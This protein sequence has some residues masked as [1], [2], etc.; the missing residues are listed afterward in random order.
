MF[1]WTNSLLYTDARGNV[2]HMNNSLRRLLIS[3]ALLAFFTGAAAG[4]PVYIITGNGTAFTVTNDNGATTLATD[5]SIQTV[6]D[7]IKVNASSAPCSIQFGNG[8]TALNIETAN[9]TFDGGAGGNDWGLITLS[10]KITS[11]NTTATAGTIS[12]T[13]G[14]SI[15]SEADVANT[16]TGT[17]GRAIYSNTTETVTISGGTVSANTGIAIYNA[18]TG[19][20]IISG[21]QTVVT[22][23][24]A[25]GTA[26]T[27]LG[28]IY[29][30]NIGNDTD[31]RLEINGGTIGNTANCVIFNVSTGAVNINGGEIS[32]TTGNWMIY[33]YSTGALNI[34]GGIVSAAGGRAIQNESAGIVTISGGE[35][36]ATTGYAVY[37]NASG[38]IHV[39][40][41]GKVYAT[42]NNGYALHNQAAGTVTI[43]G[44][45]ISATTGYAVYNNANGQIDIANATVSATGNNGYAIHNQ[46][47]GTVN[48]TD[49]TISVTSGTGSRAISNNGAGTVTIA[50]GEISATVG[51]AVYNA[52]AGRITISGAQTVIT[53]TNTTTTS[54]TIYNNAAGII[55]IIDGIVENTGG[56]NVNAIYC[57]NAGG[58]VI[59]G[60]DPEITGRI[61]AYMGKIS[62]VTGQND[63]TD[64]N[65]GNDRAYTLDLLN[66]SENTTVVANGGQQ[67]VS[68]FTLIMAEYH[69]LAAKNGDIVMTFGPYDAVL[70]NGVWVVTNNSD[71]GTW[72]HIQ[73]VI[74]H[75]KT[76]TGGSGATIQFGN[77]TDQLNIGR[78]YI[79][80]D[81]TGWGNITLTGRLTS[82]YSI[83]A[84]YGTIYLINGASITSTANISNTVASAD[85]R[86]IYNASTGTVTINGGAVSAAN[87]RAIHN[88][89]AGTVNITGGT[90]SATTG[91]AIY[92]AA[93]AG[94]ITISGG[95]QTVVTSANAATSFGTIHLAAGTAADTLLKITGGIVRN[96]ANNSSARAIYN[97][98]SGTVN[99][100]GGTVSITTTNSYTAFA[101]QNNSNGTINISGGTVHNDA[102][103]TGARAIN[104]AAAGKVTISG[105]TV[106]AAYGVAV[107]NAAANGTI[108]I[109]NG[110]V[111]SAG[112]NGYAV[113]CDN[114]NS[115][116]ALGGNP[117]IEGRIRVYVGGKL[118]VIPVSEDPINYFNPAS[119]KIYTVDLAAYTEGGVVAAGGGGVLEYFAIRQPY[120]LIKNNNN[121]VLL[122]LGPFSV[123]KIG[124]SY[125]LTAS[126]GDYVTLQEAIN[127]I[128]GEAA[129]NPCSIRFGSDDDETLNIDNKNI[130]FNGNE[131]GTTITLSGK[132]TSANTSAS[133]GTISLTN[134]VS[135]VSTADIENTYN[136]ANAYAIYNNSIGTVTISGGTVSAT[137]GRAIQNQTTGTVTVTGSGKVSTNSSYISSNYA[138]A[139]NSSGEIKI[140]GGTVAANYLAIYNISTGTVTV[141][142]GRV[143]TD[144]LYSI[145]NGAAGTITVTG[146]EVSVAGSGVNNRAIYNNST[147]PVN[148]SGGTVSATSG[149]AIYNVS[150]GKITISG[151]ATVTSENITSSSGT[152]FLAN[153]GT[154]TATR[155][156]IIGGRVENTA[157]GS[158]YY[159]A[160]VYNASTGAIDISGGTVYAANRY[161]VHNRSSGTVNV[162]GNGTISADNDYG[163]YN[164]A[165]ATVNI[166]GGTVSALRITVCNNS[167]GTINITGGTITSTSN[168]TIYNAVNGIIN[169]SGGDI[170][171]YN[172]INSYD[173]TG[174]IN[175]I[176]GKITSTGG[177]II[178]RSS[179]S[180]TGKTV[181]S[182]TAELTAGSPSSALY[183]ASGEVEITGGKIENTGGGAAIE[184]QSNCKKFVMSNLAQ[185]IS[186]GTGV[187]VRTQDAEIK[188]NG[189][190]ISTAAENGYAVY[191][192]SYNGA[193][194]SISLG[195]T[196][197]ITGR[198]TGNIGLLSVITGGPDKFEPE[199]GKIYDIDFNYYSDNGI[200]VVGGGAL[201][202]HFSLK[203]PVYAIFAKEGDIVMSALTGPYVITQENGYEF[204]I[205]WDETGSIM[206]IQ[207]ALDTIKARAAG[208][209]C[210]IQFGD[211]EIPLNTESANITF[212]G[213]T[214][215]ND[216]GKV[217]I[218]GRLLSEYASDAMQG[219]I[220]LT[221]GASIEVNADIMSGLGR[222]EVRCIYNA[223]TGSVDITGGLVSHMSGVAVYNESAGTVN[224]RGG[225][226]LT[227]GTRALYSEGPV[228]ISGGEVVAGGGAAV[229]VDGPNAVV[230]ISGSAKVSSTSDFNDTSGVI[231]MTG[232]S[233]LTITGGTVE[234]TSDR[235][236]AISSASIG[237]I[238][239]SGGTVNRFA[240][241]YYYTYAVRNS[242]TGNVYISGGTVTGPINST[243]AG[244]VTVLDGANLTRDTN[245]TS[246]YYP[247]I[248]IDTARAGAAV[249]DTCLEIKGGMLGYVGN[250]PS[251]VNS[252]Y[253]VSNHSDKGIYISGGTINGMLYQVKGQLEITGGTIAGGI[254]NDSSGVLML[255]GA[256]IID[257][258]ISTS[259]RG[260][261]GVC[262]QTAVYPFNPA[263]GVQYRLQ[264]AADLNSSRII[265]YDGFTVVKNGWNQRDKF[266]IEYTS[267]DLNVEQREKNYNGDIVI[268][269]GPYSV[270]QNGYDFTLTKSAAGDILRVQAAIDTIKAR[271]AGNE[272]SI[273]FGNG[274]ETLDVG[275][276]Y[277]TFDGGAA[278]N[279]WGKITL[280]G[281]L[282]SSRYLNYSWGYNNNPDYPYGRGAIIWLRNGVTMD[283]KAD[284]ANTSDA[285][286]YNSKTIY[287]SSGSVTISAGT[288]SAVYGVAVYGDSV[289]QITV[290]GTAV[291]TSQYYAVQLAN[292]N[293]KLD[294]SGGRVEKTGD[295]WPGYAIYNG[296]AAVN[297][298]G[299]IVDGKT[300][301]AIYNSANNCYNCNGAQGTVTISGAA[302]VTSSVSST[303]ATISGPGKL[304]ISGATVENT[305]SADSVRAIYLSDKGTVEVTGGTISAANGV[306]GFAIYSANNDASSTPA[307]ITL[308]GNPNI[309]GIMRV[310]AG[311]FTVN[312][313]T[314][315]PVGDGY[316]LD[317]PQYTDGM[318]VVNGGGSFPT[319]FTIN[320]PNPNYSVV[321]VGNDLRLTTGPYW[322]TQSVGN[323]FTLERTYDVVNGSSGPFANP[324]AAI[325]TIRVRAN[326]QD[327]SIQFGD[328]TTPLD[329][330]DGSV[331]FNGGT[332]GTDWGRITLLGKLTSDRIAY[333]STYYVS[334]YGQVTST[335][336]LGVVY[337]RRGVTVDVK[338]EISNTTST[339]GAYTI[340]TV[341]TAG[342]TNTIN[343]SAG[344]IFSERGLAVYAGSA[345]VN[346]IGGEITSNSTSSAL[347]GS[348]QITIDGSG[349]IINGSISGSYSSSYTSTLTIKNGTIN[350]S[351]SFPSN[352]TSTIIGGIINGRISNSGIL[353]ITG[354][355]VSAATGTAIYNDQTVTITG[356]TIIGETAISGSS[357]IYS[358]SNRKITVT[359]GTI[360]AT[361]VDGIAFGGADTLVLGGTPDITGSIT[362][363]NRVFRVIPSGEPN[364]FTPGSSDLYTLVVA[365]HQDGYV[366]VENGV[367][368][369]TNFTFQDLESTYFSVI[370][371][372]NNLV[373]KAA[374]QFSQGDGSENNPYIIMTDDDL[375]L[376]AS[377]IH[378]P[379]INSSYRDKHY[380]LGA[381]IN[382]ST[383]YGS[384]YS[385]G[386]GNGWIPIGKTNTPFQGT[387][388]GADFT[389]SG[390]YI[391]RQNIQYVGLF[392]YLSGTVT[393]KNLNV[394]ADY[395]SGSG[396]FNNGSSYYSAGHLGGLAGNNRGS[397]TIENCQFTG[398]ITGLGS[399]AGSNSL[400][401]GLVGSDSGSI[402]IKNCRFIGDV[403]GVTTTVNS[404]VGG[405]VGQSGSN[406][407][408]ENCDFTGNVSGA[409]TTGGSYVGGL[410]GYGVGGS[411][412]I[413]NCTIDGDVRSET[414][415]GSNDAGGLAGIINGSN[416]T[417]ENCQFTGNVRGV[418]SEA[419]SGSGHVGGLLG[420]VYG[421]AIENCHFIGGDVS[422]TV[423]TGGG[424]TGVGG[425]LGY[426]SNAAVISRSSAIANVNGSTYTGGI[427]GHIGS[428]TSELTEC[429]FDGTVTGTGYVGGLLGFFS[430]SDIIITDCVIA[431]N[432]NIIGNGYVGGVAGYFSGSGTITRTSFSANI[433][434]DSNY[435]GGLVGYSGSSGSGSTI[436]DSHTTG[437]ISAKS[438]VGGLV[439]W[440]YRVSITDSYSE[441]NIIGDSLVGGLVGSTSYITLTNSHSSGDITGTGW[442]I[443][444]LA[445]RNTGGSSNQA[446]DCYSTGNVRGASYVGGLF[447]SGYYTKII[448]SYSIGDV[449][450]TGDYIGGLA[451]LA[452]YYMEMTGSY[453]TGDVAGGGNYVGGL[454]GS[455]PS[456]SC[457]LRFTECYS[458]GNISG[459]DYV[460]GLF[461][462]NNMGGVKSS[463]ATGDVS[464]QDRVGGLMGCLV[465]C[466]SV[467]G[468]IT[469]SYSTGSVN[470]RHGVGGLVG[471]NT[472]GTITNSYTIS[473]VSG[474]DT[475]GGFVGY[476]TGNQTNISKNF[477]GARITMAPGK[478]AGGF[479]GN[480][481]TY[482]P[483]DDCYW[484]KDSVGL[485]A[486]SFTSAAGKSTDELKLAV[487]YASWDLNNTWGISDGVNMPYLRDAPVISLTY[488]AGPNGT[489]SAGV[490]QSARQIVQNIN[491]SANGVIGEPVT[492]VPDD[493]N[494]V[495][496]G[497]SDG[498]TSVTR[499]D[500]VSANMSVN[501]L[502]AS[503]DYFDSGTGD[504]NDPYMIMNAKQLA[505]MAWLVNDYNAV[506]GDKSYRLGASFSLSQD[507]GPTWDTAN[508]IGWIPIGRDDNTPFRGT[509]DGGGNTI[510]GLHINR[511]TE[512]YIGLF[513]YLGRDDDDTVTIKNVT[514][515]GTSITGQ[516]YTGGLAGSGGDF[517]GEINISKCNV[518]VIGDVEGELCVGGLLGYIGKCNIIIDSSSFVGKNV[519][520]GGFDGNNNGKGVG[521]LLGAADNGN[522]T[523][524]NSRVEADTIYSSEGGNIGGL[525]GNLSKWDQNQYVT[526]NISKSNFIGTVVSEGAIGSNNVG[527]ILGLAFN[528]VHVI[529]DSCEFEGTLF[530]SYYN[531]GGLLGGAGGDI[532]ISDSRVIADTI[533]GSKV[534]VGGLIGCT[535]TGAIDVENCYVTGNVIGGEGSVGGL[536]GVSQGVIGVE[537]C[538]VTGDVTGNGEAVGGL[539]GYSSG[540]MNI[541]NCSAAGNVT[542]GNNNV[543]G[544]A[545]SVNS[546]SSSIDSC[547]FEGTVT[548][549]SFNIGGI[550]G[551][552]QYGSVTNCYSTGMVTGT[553]AGNDNIGGIVGQ[554]AAASSGVKNCYATGAVSGGSNV[555][556][557]VGRNFGPVV[558]CAALNERVSA[559]VDDAA[560]RV[561]GY[562]GTI[563]PSG[564][565]A[566]SGMTITENGNLKTQ[567][568]NIEDGADISAAS[569]YANPAMGI[570]TGSGWATAVSRLPGFVSA[571]VT[572]EHL[573]PIFSKA[574]ITLSQN[575]YDYDGTAKKPGITKVE[576][577]GVELQE[578]AHYEVVGYANNTAVGTARVTIRGVGDLY[579]S[580]ARKNFTIIG[581][582]PPTTP[583]DAK[584]P[585]ITTQP[586]D[587]TVV[588]GASGATH[589]LT[590][591]AQ[592]P[593]GG[594]LSYQWYGNTSARNTGG[595]LIS[596]AAGASYAARIDAA[597]TFYYYVTVT[598]T[599]GNNGDGGKKT[600]SVTSDAA[601]VTVEKPKE[602]EGDEEDVTPVLSAAIPRITEQPV[603]A[604]VS[605]SGDGHT[606]TVSASVA[607]GGT[608]SYQWYNN[609]S[610]SNAGGAKIPDAT[611]KT[612]VHRQTRRGMFY[613]YAE[614]TNT[615]VA[616]SERRSASAMSEPVRVMDDDAREIAGVKFINPTS[617]RDLADRQ[618]DSAPS[619]LPVYNVTVMALDQFGSE[620]IDEPVNAQISV[621]LDDV[622]MSKAVRTN[623]RTGS[624]SFGA[625]QAGVTQGTVL[626]Y[627]AALISKG[628]R[629]ADTARLVITEPLPDLTPENGVPE[630]KPDEPRVLAGVK[631][632]SPASNRDLKAGEQPDNAASDLPVYT[633]RVMA[634]DQYG[635]GYTGAPVNMSVSVMLGGVYVSKP[636][637]TDAKT[638]TASFDVSQPGVSSGSVLTFVAAA[639]APDGAR[640]TDTARLSITEPALESTPDRAVP[641]I[642]RDEEAVAM[643]PVSLL[644]GEFMAGP[645]PVYKKSGVINFY[646]QG[647]R[648]ADSELRIYDVTGNVVSKVKISDGS[649]DSPVRRN[650]GTWDLRNDRGRPVPNGT[651]LL[652]GVLKTPDGKKENVSV[653]LGVR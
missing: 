233:A 288:V 181:V 195:G 529:I 33:N 244:K 81:G 357:Y 123:T 545:G 622:Y 50:S 318:A 390:L 535:S 573:I 25:N 196:P 242:S 202:P 299:G 544:L 389:I 190:T 132:I 130:T 150:T 201:L 118:R 337:L 32:I 259:V 46:A 253:A 597:G 83:D 637:R 373:M 112:A 306:D 168:N 366:V 34:S 140:T 24:N 230:T 340:S 601:T 125:T 80:L 556:G 457:G 330:V 21:D 485:P 329:I 114:A 345:T 15:I 59:L 423:A 176:A 421:A 362:C 537:N 426:S 222:S 419:T 395:V 160:T 264:V 520:G 156:E 124:N 632:I 191:V 188:I 565:V 66:Y 478:R 502:F 302:R 63:G 316:T 501:A 607:D 554:S 95:T 16:A 605:L 215:G 101:I 94:R 381:P 383:K 521:G 152:I 474:V 497:W 399:A 2:A 495:F 274:S 555:G 625:S 599:I 149:V 296:V 438:N 10:G 17:N 192:D 165:N 408:I 570:F 587:T 170:S 169:I 310:R 298:S 476:F 213:G 626:T 651:Y 39:N 436:T 377:V 231:Q 162:S 394:A 396:N 111:R 229:R 255:G 367:E 477:S 40:N 216:W 67:N 631:F 97:T 464:G 271:A 65:P 175:I 527:G 379:I 55:E 561:L 285:G 74:D 619:N 226:V 301:C 437:N 618:P 3:A 378:N 441:G 203:N 208:H 116:V 177:R 414:T 548:G 604:R 294:V 621:T 319:S 447:G 460:G 380:K 531:V 320:S 536:T 282:T 49:G 344:R 456:G 422:G 610:Y 571:E 591:T 566:F 268:T 462:Y 410:I 499:T 494:S 589:S 121:D 560:G 470:G 321:A 469:E 139:N 5:P 96:T 56:A 131:W 108:E 23:A 104:N 385:D 498:L 252:Y 350:G 276:E 354:G 105:G 235:G 427:A 432:V 428:S 234:N 466:S 458:A 358:Y 206:R 440:A 52:A 488:N 45:E 505:N 328:G 179:G 84:S 126:G 409:A 41:N 163:I 82:I 87:G 391:D 641:E 284:I 106:S 451:G 411:V 103:Q 53:S 506:Y 503:D 642:A 243:A 19:K 11:A 363:G 79:T 593:D 525:V 433:T 260:Q 248:R 649:A 262:P 400:V 401:G 209:D 311:K 355:T 247:A 75:I 327:C 592:S 189:G 634:L 612:Y 22:S 313:A 374:A 360:T 443:G 492:A 483:T 572:P 119:G 237:D 449:S 339:Y 509:F 236:T 157:V 90:V 307:E 653:I 76:Q 134:G 336:R 403:S 167:A 277:I 220:Y 122:T 71:N 624:A 569:I 397:A 211:G 496:N 353:T 198:I 579:D 359:G 69:K 146:G 61:R 351:V 611:E 386:G 583:V 64:F 614:V 44:G 266:I 26:S 166:S 541:E 364:A 582:E 171:G 603:G 36:S 147:G 467:N 115:N 407:T 172:V 47:A 596:G 645:N 563:M 129:G 4:Q 568:S 588:T 567:L 269:T 584:E 31:T 629:Y 110:T 183:I 343:I 279:A 309:I 217:T 528:F 93:A 580:T 388:D 586:R 159:S 194:T 136:Y 37:N 92:N 479:I 517:Y 513:G 551:V 387:F 205:L 239:I 158:S 417:I 481:L 207:E 38:Q 523:V 606:M 540:A 100:D 142:G 543:G 250:D 174:T 524:S 254:T 617:N 575:T 510:I 602:D 609:T 549:H 538:H 627:T 240:S 442:Y 218:L 60:G 267:N 384:Q 370:P 143:S 424:Y 224:V 413:K 141:S 278:R 9:V 633:V 650:V 532:R 245:T 598:N 287:S 145:Y 265:T 514:V 504:P 468:G 322:I 515:T 552:L 109:I 522:I 511:P 42:G 197:D 542:G 615:V 484:N 315:T 273:T 62:A 415:T 539:I 178:E 508:G 608:L 186:Q 594:K 54:G 13:N 286:G 635:K 652:R 578:T 431:E 117:N 461:G 500:A 491:P 1:G 564:N 154:A 475:V 463:Y 323:V 335:I 6:I 487:T 246:G 292:A 534:Q 371:A 452:E 293:A 493:I 58:S 553:G 444:G 30:A 193:N 382:L 261:F 574:V 331:T 212:D 338:S 375:A 482:I 473:S 228:N 199:Q 305:S 347:T 530:G 98:A 308:D 472:S 210:S 558:N 581:D 290:S 349:T 448:D 283:S 398:D 325:D 251:A 392:G 334:G 91:N 164:Y 616:G 550:V 289:A 406:I 43:S 595:T 412:I 429:L 185:I 459:T 68:K 435:V 161:G 600:A 8:T 643:A 445:G 630:I 135:I 585:V 455:V 72:V 342:F 486:P 368:F 151:D 232:G 128:K 518:S 628:V 270:T 425:L 249:R 547:K 272:C 512:D 28:T 489:L 332:T 113:Y 303:T 326:K 402:T 420:F 18:S 148:I 238:I 439:G 623:V 78:A 127:Y 393:I 490:R 14:V 107:Y 341:D 636:V 516:N 29:L 346:V 221:N 533:Y 88:Q 295:N 7:A 648:V 77:T 225:R 365:A 454:A 314:F 258:V 219:I 241:N 20:I 89:V 155:L 173:G 48:I 647:R 138:I 223:S 263:Q 200:A 317:F 471:V 297:I 430:S 576:L 372:G 644:T 519:K 446:A 434:A 620:Y 590:V 280:L 507:Y 557:I 577:E 275:G 613:Y 256:P 546:P 376:M 352:G 133:Q 369:Q 639:L 214:G 120:R 70:N 405:L 465:G 640:F 281:K 153:S 559:A 450:G 57:N 182:G 184:L 562:N 99:I 356:G 51:Q 137:Y 416:N 86:T 361:G 300:S 324:Q 453:S 180:G 85:V 187:L 418:R 291:V 257:G 646:R 27:P 12:L 73:D 312:D 348:G 404:H 35:V 227:L 638:G 144:T 480:T 304:I 204:N 333:D 526:V 102:N